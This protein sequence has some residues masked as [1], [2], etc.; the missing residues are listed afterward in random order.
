MGRQELEVTGQL[1]LHPQIVVIQ[2]SDAGAAGAAPSRIESRRLPL[3]G[4][5]DNLE[6]GIS[7]TLQQYRGG[8]RRAVV[9]H[10]KLEILK[11]LAL[12]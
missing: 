12:H 2:E 7:Y 10:D 8:V 4:L 9:N 3:V 1:G 6:A 11:A 5:P